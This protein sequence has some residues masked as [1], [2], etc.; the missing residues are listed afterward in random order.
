MREAQ[1]YT[2]S[3]GLELGLAASVDAKYAET[4]VVTVTEVGEGGAGTTPP[5]SCTPTAEPQPD[6]AV[7]LLEQS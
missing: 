3:P 1:Q 6:L 4:A 5:A 2:F 7:T